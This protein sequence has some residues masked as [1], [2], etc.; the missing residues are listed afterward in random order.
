MRGGQFI[1]NNKITIMELTQAIDILKA[2]AASKQAEA[3]A[4]NLAVSVL[5]DKFAPELQVLE[6]ARAEVVQKDT[7]ISEK[8]AK[9]EAISTEKTTLEAQVQELSKT[10]VEVAP[11][12]EKA[13][14]V[15]PAEEVA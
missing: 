9:I 13:E 4:L 1:K 7:I 12:I 5:E 8:T 2:S 3:D 6:N 10:D 11:V 15:I 14:D